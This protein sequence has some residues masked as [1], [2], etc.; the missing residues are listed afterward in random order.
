MPFE[1][2]K[3]ILSRE[4]TPLALRAALFLSRLRCAFFAIDYFLRRCCQRDDAATARYA[5]TPPPDA[6]TP[7]F[8]EDISHFHICFLHAIAIRYAA[9]L[10][11]RGASSRCF[12]R[13]LMFSTPCRR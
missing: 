6:M 2:R 7:I 3:Q 5:V 13:R 8:D 11:F 10:L 9:S 1:A 12:L 4:R